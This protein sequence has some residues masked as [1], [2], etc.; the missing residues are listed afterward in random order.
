MSKT[1]Y[2]AKINP[3][4]NWTSI[5][6][7]TILYLSKKDNCFCGD[8]ASGHE[9]KDD[10]IVKAGTYDEGPA[11]ECNGCGKMIESSYGDPDNELRKK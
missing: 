9:D 2:I 6:G 1:V 11:I 3:L 4:P 10:P 5:G 7:Y 8:C